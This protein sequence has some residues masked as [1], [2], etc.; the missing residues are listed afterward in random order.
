MNVLF[1]DNHKCRPSSAHDECCVCVEVCSDVI[2]VTVIF[3]MTFYVPFFH[4]PSVKERFLKRI[5]FAWE[6]ILYV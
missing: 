6:L 2:L 5:F 1:K 3:I 4:L